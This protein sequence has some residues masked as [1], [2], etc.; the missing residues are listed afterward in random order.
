MYNR[1]ERTAQRRFD[2]AKRKRAT[3]RKMFW[4]DE[5]NCLVVTI[6]VSIPVGL[7]LGYLVYPFVK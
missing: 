7:L 6:Y 2:Y 4:A 5:L 1:I 3:A